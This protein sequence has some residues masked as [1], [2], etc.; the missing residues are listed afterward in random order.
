MPIDDAER[1]QLLRELLAERFGRVRT[2]L[3]A[4]A[5]DP[6]RLIAQRRRVLCG[7]DE[8]PAATQEAA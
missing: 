5:G 6:P 8:H 2:S 4:V 7:L 3:R 1:D